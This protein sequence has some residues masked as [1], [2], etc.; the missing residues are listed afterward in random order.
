MERF[1]EVKAWDEVDVKMGFER[2]ESGL[3]AGEEKVGWLVNMHQ[4]SYRTGMLEAEESWNSYICAIA[5]AWDELI[6]A[7][8]AAVCY[9]SHRSGGGRLLLHPG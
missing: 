7:D 6:R 9:T 8:T 4:V 3:A 5:G 1:E 2:F